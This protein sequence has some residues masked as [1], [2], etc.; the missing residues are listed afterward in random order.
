MRTISAVFVTVTAIAAMSAPALAREEVTVVPDAVFWSKITDVDTGACE[1]GLRSLAAAGLVPEAYAGLLVA[2]EG[3][4]GFS[5]TESD[6][7]GG[8]SIIRESGGYPISPSFVLSDG[9][10]VAT[11]YTGECT[12]H[13]FAT[14]M[15]TDGFPRGF[16]DNAGNGKSYA[17]GLDP[18]T[19]LWNVAGSCD[20]WMVMLTPSSL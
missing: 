11:I 9:D 16:V 2:P 17:Y 6:V 4:G 3:V 1:R 18:G 14:L 5:A 8:V 7:A 13:T 19:Y 20:D 15:Q 12:S 10:Y